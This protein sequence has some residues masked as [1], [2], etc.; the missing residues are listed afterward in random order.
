MTTNLIFSIPLIILC[1]KT[2][3]THA[4]WIS[5]QWKNKIEKEEANT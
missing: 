3:E 2:Q 4:G 5:L 1:E